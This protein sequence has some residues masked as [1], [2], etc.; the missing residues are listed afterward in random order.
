MILE[1]EIKMAVDDKPS[2]ILFNYDK[3]NNYIVI[4]E[5]DRK[6]FLEYDSNTKTVEIK[7]SFINQI[8]NLL[9]D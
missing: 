8:A 5:N 3:D 4:E 7:T 9:V 1:S 2:N 6:Q